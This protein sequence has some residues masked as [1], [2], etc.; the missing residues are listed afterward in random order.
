[1]IESFDPDPIAFLREQGARWASPIFRWALSARRVT[2]QT[3][4]PICPTRGA[5][6]SRISCIF[7]ARVRISSPGT[8]PICR[9]RSRCCCARACGFPSRHGPCA[10]KNRRA[11]REEMG[12]SDRVRRVCALTGRRARPEFS[13]ASAPLLL[14]SLRFR[15]RCAP[16]VSYRSRRNFRFNRPFT[17]ICHLFARRRRCSPTICRGGCRT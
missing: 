4:G 14:R 3:N 6:N 15:D 11:R 16:R 7:R 5:T 2:T 9:T 1:M 10:R 12:G 17:M 13:S 8:S